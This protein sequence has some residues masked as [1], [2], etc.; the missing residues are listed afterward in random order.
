MF[1]P[2]KVRTETEPYSFAVRND[3]ST[4]VGNRVDDQVHRD[5]GGDFG[6]N[7]GWS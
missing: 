7:V 1:E 4:V 3:V 2:F 5:I 6:G